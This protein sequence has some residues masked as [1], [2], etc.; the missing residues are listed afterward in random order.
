MPKVLYRV[1]LTREERAEL[2]DISRNG[3]RAARVVLNALVLL[4]VDQ[5]EFQE[6]PK[7][8][9]QE[10]AEVLN[11]TQRSINHIKERFVEKGMNAAIERAPRAAR[12]VGYDG[13]FEAHLTALACSKAPEGHARWS[14]RLLADRVVKLQYANKISHET[15]RQILKKTSLS[16]GKGR[17]G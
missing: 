7:K 8:P 15:V 3:H 13:D 2:L 17:N 11:I 5:G 9:E 16:L 1:T 14:L 6:N 12:G 4:A 10:V